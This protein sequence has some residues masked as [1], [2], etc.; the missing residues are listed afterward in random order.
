MRRTTA[1]AGCVTGIASGEKVARK[2]RLGG[3][4]EGEIVDMN[5]NHRMQAYATRQKRTLSTKMR[6]RNGDAQA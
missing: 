2:S 6:I 3:V 5:C 4:T 1:A